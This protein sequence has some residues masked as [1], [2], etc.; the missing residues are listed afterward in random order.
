MRLLNSSSGEMKD[1]ISYNE[2]PPYAILS[3]TW[4]DDEV[5]FQDWQYLPWPEVQK[6]E[7]YRKIEYCCQQASKEGLE[8][9]WADTCCID[10]TSSAELTES[11]NS[12]FR[13]YRN[14]A[15][16]YAFLAD[17][18]HDLEPSRLEENLGKSRWFTRGWTLQELIAPAEVVFY[19]MDWHQVGTKS[20]LSTCI[21]NITLIEET[22][23]DG[24]NIEFASIAQ[25]MSWAAKRQTSRDEDVAYCLLGIFDVNMPLIY[26]E[27]P[28][29]F[30][31]LQKEIM[32]AYP[33]D[34]TLFAWGIIHDQFT[35]FVQSEEQ[36][37]GD[38]PIEWEPDSDESLLGFLAQSPKDFEFS[39]KIVIYREARKF[40]RRWDF[41]LTAGEIVGRTVRLALP[42]VP[43]WHRFAA[44]HLNGVPTVRL[45]R[46]TSVVLVCGRQNPNENFQFV[47]DS[48][49]LVTVPLLICTGGYHGRTRELVLNRDIALPHIK[50]D[51]LGLWRQQIVIERQPEYRPRRGDIILRRF[52]SF[53]ACGWSIA[54]DTIDV[55]IDDGYIKALGPTHGRVACLAFEYDDVQGVGMI[56]G[57]VGENEDGTG[58]L[59]FGVMPVD[60]EASNEQAM[61]EFPSA[62]ETSE[63]EDVVE[64]QT[65][66]GEEV[67][68]EPEEA[69]PNSESGESNGEEGEDEVKQEDHGEVESE[70]TNEITNNSEGVEG[71]AKDEET[72][73]PAA[74][75]HSSRS[76]GTQTTP[77]PPYTTTASGAS[78]GV[79][80]PQK[81]PQ[82]SR[83]P[84]PSLE[85]SQSPSH[86]YADSNAIPPSPIATPPSPISSTYI[87]PS[88][89]PTPPSPSHSQHL[90]QFPD[91]RAAFYYLWDHWDGAP[92][93]HTMDMS[94][95]KTQAWDLPENPWVPRVQ[96]R[97]ERMYIDDDP[98]EPVDVIDI[99]LST[100]MGKAGRSGMR[101]PP[102][103]PQHG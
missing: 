18:P 21:S 86:S 64:D 39:G 36:V 46:V 17:V 6:K 98:D 15:V 91:M 30:Q 78:S 80:T 5:S 90:P 75:K 54:G 100:T 34:H 44:C 55:A 59:L 85:S 19:S 24:A 93:S 92:Y 35:K 57:R 70:A 28:K 74:E 60:R 79:S 26:G 37:L 4:C 40:F 99:V 22:Y 62:G 81:T 20:Q 67:R 87:S 56:I 29:A 95:G 16:C 61:I 94:S 53:V 43:S 65:E 8:W 47:D 89:T 3:H 7:G 49:I 48:V 102:T 101:L 77:P 12:M 50:Y 14:A 42:R 33:E 71:E 2:I 52:I 72:T 97:A 68:T 13:W 32:Q 38:A 31:R 83:T 9:V 41:P 96:V 82:P 23:L 25:R 1:F 11:I 58:D 10:K 103:A 27:G 88:R 45:R 69:E 73:E 63:T 51:T 84:S 66:N 76:Q